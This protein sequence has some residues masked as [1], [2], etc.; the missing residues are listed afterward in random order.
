MLGFSEVFDRT[1]IVKAGVLIFFA[2]SPTNIYKS[3]L[4]MNG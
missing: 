4:S 2:L 3:S 1:L